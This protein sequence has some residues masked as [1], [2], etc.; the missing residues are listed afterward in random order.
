MKFLS[1][2]VF[3]DYFAVNW[4]FG[5]GKISEE[6]KKVALRDEVSVDWRISG[7]PRFKMDFWECQRDWSK[8]GLPIKQKVRGETHKTT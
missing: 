6:K 1:I 2:G 8:T 4:I 7:L 3:R 5:N